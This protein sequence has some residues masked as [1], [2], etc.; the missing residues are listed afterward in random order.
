MP[1]KGRRTGLA[2]AAGII[3]L[4][5][6]VLGILVGALFFA[7]TAF[8]SQLTDRLGEIPGLPSGTNTSDILAGAFVFLGVIV[9]AYSL[10]YILGGIGVLRSRGWGRVLGILVGLFSGLFWL[11]ALGGGGNQG[12]AFVAI[13]FGVHAYIFVV[14]AFFWRSKARA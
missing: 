8:V 12:G 10:A 3:L 4:I 9:L 6:G 14:L 5:L 13:L 7:G 2:A 11:L 1:V